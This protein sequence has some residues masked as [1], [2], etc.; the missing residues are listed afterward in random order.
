MSDD[1][2]DKPQQSLRVRQEDSLIKL[3]IDNKIPIIGVC[4][5]FQRINNYLSG[6]QS[7]IFEK[8]HVNTIHE[9]SWSSTAPKYLS[10][11]TANVNSFHNYI[12]NS[13]EL[14]PELDAWA[15]SNNT[16]EMAVHSHLPLVGIMW[17]PE[18]FNNP[19]LSSH[20]MGFEFINSILKWM[21][22]K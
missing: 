22:K 1:L 17:H 9:I 3:A 12:I 13:E 21:V 5:G 10:T 20:L 6:S 2:K 8:T 7:L 16:V 11:T 15:F 4:R 14:S 19:N 18:R